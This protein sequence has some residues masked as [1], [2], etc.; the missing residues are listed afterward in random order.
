MNVKQQLE[1]FAWHY[2]AGI[3]FKKKNGN[4][5]PLEKSFAC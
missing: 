4:N 3:N 5:H 2:N 1:T